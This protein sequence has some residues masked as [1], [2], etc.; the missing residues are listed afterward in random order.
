MYWNKCRT[1]VEMRH[2][3]MDVMKQAELV[4]KM[5]QEKFPSW[6]ARRSLAISHPLPL[7]QGT[8]FLHFQMNQIDA[9]RD[10]RIQ[11]SSYVLWP[12]DFQS[13]KRIV[14]AETIWGNM[15]NSLFYL[16][17]NL[18]W[19]YFLIINFWPLAPFYIFINLDFFFIN[20]TNRTFQKIPISPL[21]RTIKHFTNTFF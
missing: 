10:E 17:V 7:R 4:G 5:M 1:I 20:F 13:Q 6:L 19:F 21:T 9:T 8:R 15:L 11:E 18:N 12:L 2:P 3:K 16:R 14:F